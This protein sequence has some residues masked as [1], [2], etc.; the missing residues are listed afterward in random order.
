MAAGQYT[1]Q[2][3][4]TE[5]DGV[6]E[7]NNSHQKIVD[8]PFVFKRQCNEKRYKKWAQHFYGERPAWAPEFVVVP[9]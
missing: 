7:N 9:E 8:K 1:Q 4:K 2:K 6:T 5:T 3:M